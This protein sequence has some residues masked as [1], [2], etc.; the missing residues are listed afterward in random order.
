M[1]IMDSTLFKKNVR[2]WKPSDNDYRLIFRE[3]DGFW[4]EISG[5]LPRYNCVFL[6]DYLSGVGVVI[7]EGCTFCRINRTDLHFEYRDFG[8]YVRID[9]EIPQL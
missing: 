5:N 6:A 1:Q 2:G 7:P 4:R 3:I 9:V 8:S